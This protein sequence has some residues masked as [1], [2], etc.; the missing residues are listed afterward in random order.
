MLLKSPIRS[1][2]SVNVS[3]PAPTKGLNARDSLADMD[4][5][6]AVVMDNYVPMDSGVASRICKLC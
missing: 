3:L 2:K 6:Y 1:N 5:R 4:S